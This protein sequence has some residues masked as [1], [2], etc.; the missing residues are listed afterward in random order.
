MNSPKRTQGLHEKYAVNPAQA[1]A[2]VWGRR[3][4]PLTRRGFLSNGGLLAMAT[5]LG[6]KIVFSDKMPGGLI[7]AALAQAP[8][9]FA[10]PGK[11][12]LVYL[13]DRPINAETPAH[14]LDDDVTPANRLFMRNNGHPPDPVIATVA[15]F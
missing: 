1:D 6:A 15:C 5:V 11:D 9:P 13:N 3:V 12:G 10:V 8:E 4:H 7:P 14:L 2:D